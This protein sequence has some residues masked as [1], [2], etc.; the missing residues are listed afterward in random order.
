MSS[1]RVTQESLLAPA[2]AAV[3]VSAMMALGVYATDARLASQLAL[4]FRQRLSPTV[5]VP[6][7]VIRSLPSLLVALLVAWIGYRLWRLMRGDSGV[8]A[9]L[10]SLVLRLVC[11]GVSVV[12]VLVLYATAAAKVTSAVEAGL[13]LS[14]IFLPGIIAL[15]AFLLLALGLLR[16]GIVPP[17]VAWAGVGATVLSGAAAALS[18]QAMWMAFFASST[19][20]PSAIQGLAAVGGRVAWANNLS[21]GVY[22]LFWIALA[23]AL[24][25]RSAEPTV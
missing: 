16:S 11:L 5:F 6:S 24:Y 14:W 3:A 15:A 4:A 23:F 8:R 25:T 7:A 17:W 12:L 9:L 10:A 18:A 2:I 21:S 20:Y 1:E 19:Q 13:L 22:A